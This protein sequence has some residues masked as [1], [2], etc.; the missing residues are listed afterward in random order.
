MLH[1]VR[2]VAL[3]FL[4]ALAIATPAG[5]A[6]SG[7]SGLRPT[8]DLDGARSVLVISLPATAWI[9]IRDAR[10]P[11]LTR[12][13]R[14]SALADLATRTVRNRTL[15][16]AGYIA[17]GAGGRSVARPEDAAINMQGTERFAG[18]DAGAVFAT[19][20]GLAI[21][22]GVGALG[23]PQLVAQND[24]TS[25]DT[26]IGALG[27]ALRSA[28]VGR[29]VIANADETSLAGPV[30]RREAAL[31]VM[32]ETGRTP[33]RVTGITRRAPLA[34]YGRLLD[35][36][37]VD[38]AFPT[39]FTTRRQVVLVEASDLA[40]ADDYRPLASPEQRAALH[41]RA[42]ARSDELVGRLLR[43][44]DLRRDAV[45][46]VSPYHS[47]RT[48]TLTVAAIHAP[49][50]GTGLLESATSR[51]AGF[52]QIVDL[53]PT[54]LDL[55]DVEPPK[56]MEG[57]PARLH[58]ETGDYRERIDRLV[59]ADR[60]AQFRDAT[61]G[62][63]TAILVVA[64]IVLAF[65][66]AL[67]FRFGRRT[68]VTTVL[69]WA[70][71]AMLGFVTATF[72]AGLFPFFRWGTAAYFPFV[73][74]VALG[75]A[76]ICLVAGRRGR[77]D[78]IL[79]ALGIVVAL[80]LGDLFT[81]AHLQFNTVFGY[82]PTVGIRLAGI[83]NPGSAQVSI[84]ALLFAILI[85]W[86]LPRRGPVIGYVVVGVTL[87]AV[88][89]PLWGQ[90]YGGALALAP[91]LVLWWLLHSQRR[92]RWRSLLT[93]IGVLVVTGLVAGFVD[94]SRPSNQRTH[95]GRFFEKIGDDGPA[96]FFTVIGRK[97]GLMIGTFSN[98]AWVLL[99]LSVLVVIYLAFRRTHAMA[100][101]TAAIP[102]LTPGLVCVAVLVVLAT[103]LNDSGVQVTG[104]MLATLLPVLV[105]LAT[106]YVDSD[107][108]DDA[109]DDAD[110]PPPTPA[111]PE[112][113]PTAP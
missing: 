46:V 19:R 111:V 104:M 53:A 90:D 48:R 28:G 94:L 86:R 27:T 39:D 82:S 60:A 22:S 65:A 4:A 64:T 108:T 77:A 30:P 101:L 96:G 87:V 26:E 24:A 41:A 76:A 67:W 81:G 1:R 59:R 85:T 99:V 66:A 20:T 63:A 42:L 107:A 5:A 79:V 37:A 102:T 89:A 73:I 110:A 69:A 56:A 15:A 40:R 80:H 57:R 58:P 25:Y 93:I 55:V 44:V 50:G 98:T 109:P 72:L 16:G 17:L 100:R 83:G 32:D 9:D 21:G 54:I 78:P 6:G 103:A 112:L 14:D 51:R 106:R 36:D 31:G 75:F 11:N 95:V 33:G 88:G 45:V 34:P 92:I 62:Q 84:A 18:T 38:A 35:L 47:S 71:L 61:I 8:E 105:F 113:E 13:L 68:A 52:L 10:P 91:T 49:N 3:V 43:H 97:L 23:W 70:A 2:A 7:R 74:V 12:L 29:F